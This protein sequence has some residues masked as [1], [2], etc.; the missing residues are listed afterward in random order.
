MN[1]YTKI[2]CA[3]S[4]PGLGQ[5][6]GTFSLIKNT[7]QVLDQTLYFADA[8]VDMKYQLYPG[9]EVNSVIHVGNY[10]V[11]TL[12]NA[13]I[14]AGKDYAMVYKVGRETVYASLVISGNDLNNYLL[15]KNLKSN[16]KF[17]VLYYNNINLTTYEIGEFE[18]NFRN[19]NFT[20][21]DGNLYTENFKSTSPKLELKKIFEE[22]YI[23]PPPPPVPPVETPWYFKYAIHML[24]VIVIVGLV[25]LVVK[26]YKKAKAK[27]LE[28]LRKEITI[29]D[30]LEH[31][32]YR[33]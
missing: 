17:F 11:I 5:Y 30:K 12:I 29:I 19:P 15:Y 25:V 14:P 32:Y 10:I 8:V 28:K 3:M 20:L 33:Y 26:L 4:L 16:T 9:G 31:F 1:E 7:S 13:E 23:V 27:R 21:V 24:V 22:G 2:N 6:I 18:L